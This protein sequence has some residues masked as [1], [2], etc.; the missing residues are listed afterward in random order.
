MKSHNEALAIQREIGD[1]SGVSITLIS[2][3]GLLNESLGRP[4]EALPLFRE[5]LSLSR[6]E[7][8]RSGEAL[9]LNNIGSAYLSKGEF[10]EAQT[11][12]ERALDIREQT[13]VPEEMA[14]TLHNLGETLGKMGKYDQALTRYLRA[15]DLRRTDGDTYRY[16]IAQDGITLTLPAGTYSNVSRLD[17]FCTT[18]GPA[19]VLQERF[20]LSPEVLVPIRY[21]DWNAQF[22][23]WSRVHSLVS[24]TAK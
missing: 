23:C 20:Y 5:A 16:E 3:G 4:D 12:F 1:K 2:L 15:L 19:W 6:E 10:S 11:N 9:A 8:D 13:N 22:G 24:I 7:G 17:V 21:L 18:C 14:N